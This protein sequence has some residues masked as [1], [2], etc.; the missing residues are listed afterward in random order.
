MQ[1]NRLIT[2]NIVN[3]LLAGALVMLGSLTD[4]Q[5]TTQGIFFALV[6]GSL[7]AVTKFKDFW[8][9]S[10]KDLKKNTFFNFI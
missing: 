7:V 6:A 9:A 8:T 3:S 10:G 1:N 5:I 2:Y 4:G